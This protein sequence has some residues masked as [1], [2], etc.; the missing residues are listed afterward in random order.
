MDLSK[1]RLEL[2]A[3]ALFQGPAV[4]F[5]VSFA[6]MLGCGQAECANISA[7][8]SSA[9]AVVMHANAGGK[10]D[11]YSDRFPAIKIS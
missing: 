3:D 11:D 5:A 6:R 2:P 1:A 7:T 9:L 4:D 10:S 8:V